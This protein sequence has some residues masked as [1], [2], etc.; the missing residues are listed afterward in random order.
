MCKSEPK[1]VARDERKWSDDVSRKIGSGDKLPAP[2]ETSSQGG[3][4]DSQEPPT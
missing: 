4:K 1:G 2:A 3:T